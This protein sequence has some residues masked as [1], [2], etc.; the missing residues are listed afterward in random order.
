MN[1]KIWRIFI[2]F[3]KIDEDVY[4][5]VIPN[6]E[7]SKIYEEHFIRYFNEYIK[8][9]KKRWLEALKKEDVKTANTILNTILESSISF[10]DNYEAFY[11]GF[12][13]GLLSDYR[14]KSNR[15]SGKGRFDVVVLPINLFQKCIV[16]E[17]KKAISP[18]RLEEEA[19]D[20]VNQI[21]KNKYIEGLQYDG[22]RDIVGYGIAFYQK[23]AVIAKL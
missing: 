15:E 4:E 13:L 6:K 9:D 14:V 7:V 10:Y 17:C 21:V 8:D 23:S 18:L 16:I 5:L 3:Y 11:H 19:N 12:I 22:Y 2:V 20:A 1:L